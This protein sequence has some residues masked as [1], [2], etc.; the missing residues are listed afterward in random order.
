MFFLV[1]RNSSNK[2]R[3]GTAVLIRGRRFALINFF[4]ANAALIRGHACSGAALIRVN[5]VNH[6]KT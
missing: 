1:I 6:A 3:I 5:T 4:V 2:V